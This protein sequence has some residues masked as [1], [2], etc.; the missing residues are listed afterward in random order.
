MDIFNQYIYKLRDLCLNEPYII[1][2]DD[3]APKL[4]HYIRLLDVIKFEDG[5][6]HTY[7]GE[8]KDILNSFTDH[9]TEVMDAAIREADRISH[10][11]TK[12]E[13]L[14]M[15]EKTISMQEKK[16]LNFE[17]EFLLNENSSKNELFDNLQD[18]YTKYMERFHNIKDELKSLDKQDEIQTFAKEQC[19]ISL[20]R[21]N[22]IFAFTYNFIS[23]KLSLVI[24]R[25]RVSLEEIL[26]RFQN[27]VRTME[28]I[29]EVDLSHL[30]IRLYEKSK[31]HIIL[32]RQDVRSSGDIAEV[33]RSMEILKDKIEE[34]KHMPMHRLQEE[35]K[36]WTDKISEFQQIE[37]TM[38]KVAAEE[39]NL[40][41]QEKL[42]HEL[43]KTEIPPAKTK[44]WENM[45]KKSKQRFEELCE[46]KLNA[47]KA[48]STF[49]S[50]RGP[51]RIY[52]TDAIGTYFVD[53]YGHQCYVFDHGL[54]SYHV[55]CDGN[56]I[57]KPET[58]PYFF[59][60]NGRFI[61]TKDSEK[62]YQIGPCTSTY[63]IQN[64]LFVKHS[65]DC[66]HS[67]ALK[68]DCRMEIKDHT[69]YVILPEVK[70][71]DIKGKL[72]PEDAKYLWDTF[73][74]ILP[75]VL[76][77][78]AETKPKNPI[79]ILAHK[80]LT[81]KYKTSNTEM[82]KKKEEARKY[83]E[84]KINALHKAWKSKQVKRRKPEESDDTMD[85]F[86]YNSYKN[87]QNFILSL[88]NY[89]V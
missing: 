29:S 49:F 88:E 47:A 51:D 71:V 37:E 25:I 77:D 18:K 46:M 40:L 81:Y 8:I 17:K 10:S 26:N 59:D 2:I 38:K 19:Q 62:F 74:H 56:F 31:E 35:C 69:D 45:E 21:E 16:Q 63:T 43:K 14:Q 53:E 85:R 66:G 60:N 4:R 75:D 9:W 5:S 73:G 3:I 87:E 36:Y 32:S 23:Y 6:Y 33:Q 20:K 55:D 24:D 83:Q 44:C 86:V 82:S 79:H 76:C 41:E 15:I 64:D 30:L 34:T 28:E 22:D 54:N 65:K 27:N 50:V 68:K 58:D 12:S 52:Y 11:L 80:L 70:P 78:V 61:V 89:N 67:E 1:I 42:L 7:Y 72:S 39:K 57:K 48:L 13:L 84:K